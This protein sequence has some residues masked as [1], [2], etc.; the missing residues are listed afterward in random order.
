MRV[1]VTGKCCISISSQ[2]FKLMRYLDSTGASGVLGTA[3]YNAY[4]SAGATVLGLA[5][6]RPTGDLK[7]LDLLD[8]ESTQAVFSDF[9]P[10]CMPCFP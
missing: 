4:K 1:I 8:T 2:F 10:D 9:K 6:S 5:H 3:V 7:K